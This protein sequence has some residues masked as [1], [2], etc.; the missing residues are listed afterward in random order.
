MFSPTG[1][2]HIWKRG[3]SGWSPTPHLF[4]YN[5]PCLFPKFCISVV[6]SFSWESCNTQKTLKT[7]VMQYFC[8]GG[9]GLGGAG[10]GWMESNMLY[11]GRNANREFLISTQ[12]S[13]VE[14]IDRVTH[15]RSKVLFENSKWRRVF[16]KVIFIR[17]RHLWW[18]VSDGFYGVILP[19]FVLFRDD[20]EF[21]VFPLTS[22]YV[23]M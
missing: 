21:H 19:T 16:L 4:K 20:A 13:Q 18:G 17:K 12:N 10:V 3:Q 9:E 15:F 5:A 23:I 14:I 6:F 22:W 2:R 1:H 11:Y 8:L 7:K